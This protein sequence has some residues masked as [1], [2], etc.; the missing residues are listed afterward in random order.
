MIAKSNSANRR[1]IA[2]LLLVLPALLM[3]MVYFLFPAGISVFY[4]IT[5][6]KGVGSFNIIG[7]NNFITLFTK[8]PYFWKTFRNTL[9][10]GILNL[11]I[12]IPVAFIL[13]QIVNKEFK[14]ATLLKAIYFSPQL[15]ATVTAALIWLFILD[16]TTGILNTVLRNVGLGSLALQWVGGME[17][18]PYSAGIIGTWQSAGYYMCIFLAG[19]KAIPRDLYESATID[20]ATKLQEVFRITIPMLFQTFKT[21]LIFV[22]TGALR[23]FDLVYTMTRGGPMH[24]SDT[25]IS[26]MYMLCFRNHRY[27]FGMAI[28]T[29]VFALSLA[30]SLLLMKLMSKDNTD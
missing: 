6:T 22:V 2:F 23:S 19:M 7:I 12:T 4:S 5:D 26:Y 10:M 27:G 3:Y 30:L 28:V 25:M 18:T 11:V 1:K 17:L 14:G 24:A 16:P 21:V 20:G 9:I 15:I 29:V 8:D 13:A